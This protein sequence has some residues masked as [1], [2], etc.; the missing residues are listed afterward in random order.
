MQVNQ[1]Y[2]FELEPNNIQLGS[3]RNHAGA[4]R[5]AYN[6]GLAERIKSYDVQKKTEGK[7]K[8]LTA[9]DQHKSLV[10]LKK[11]KLSWMYEVSKC[12]PQ[13]ALRDLEKAYQNFF[14][15]VKNG[16]KPGFPRFKK[17]GGNDSFRLTGSVQVN[18]TSIQLPKIGVVRTKESTE[19]FS[20]RI[21]SVTVKR[22]ADRWYA[23]VCVEAERP[24]PKPVEGP[25]C[26]VD[27][28]LAEIVIHNGDSV[29][30]IE[31][32]RSIKQDLVALKR[33]QKNLSKKTKGSSNR[34]KQVMRVA[35]IHARIARRR[36]DFLNVLTARLA[37]AK[38]VIVV[39]DLCVKGM[40]RNHNL[41]QAIADAGW[42]SFVTMLGYKCLWYGS[43]L[44]KVDRFYPSSKTCSECGEV[45]KA[46]ALSEREWACKACGSWHERDANAALNL[47]NRG[48]EILEEMKTTASHAGSEA[49]GDTSGSGTLS[50]KMKRPTSRVS[51]KQE[52]S[53]GT[54][55]PHSL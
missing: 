19:K 3:F 39:E 26:G 51:V 13:E 21:L 9:I 17:K 20:G 52:E 55:V 15:R 14:R 41:A 36:K 16:E 38:S 49:C 24:T 37:K 54:S 8:S 27:L 23:S 50:R 6:W 45:N 11:D 53:C 34:K 40:L 48:L 30:R 18:P 43:T 46:L 25:V 7:K 42:G 35:K 2:R 5:F 28:N 47:R 33:A 29:D 22:V 1:S 31:T 10:K 32:P 44:I 4:A 12:A